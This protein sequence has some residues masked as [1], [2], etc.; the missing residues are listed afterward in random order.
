MS[1]RTDP[2]PAMRLR[3]RW[4]AVVIAGAASLPVGCARSKVAPPAFTIARTSPALGADADPVLLNDS[5]TVYFADTLS[6]LSVTADSVTV[7]DE[8]GR[9]VPGQLRSGANWV[10]FVPTPPLSPSLDDG[11]FRPA[12]HLRL[13][14]AGAPRPDAVC[15]ADGRRLHA[16][17]VYD[18][19]VAAADH[20]GAGLIAPLR[21]QPPELPFLLPPVDAPQVLPADAPVLRLH[22]T[23]PV[24]PTTLT[25]EAFDIRVLRNRETV[26]LRPRSVRATT[27]QFDEFPGSTVEVDLGAMPSLPSGRPAGPLVAGDWVSVDLVR[28]QGLTDYA[29]EAPLPTSQPQ[30]WNVVA[31]GNVALV[32]WP[33]SDGGIVGD[34]PLLPGFETV[35]G[36]VRPRVR[37]EA[38]DGSLGV[39]RPQRDTLLRPGQPFDRGD[40]QIVFSRGSEFPFLAI[41]IPAGV[42]VTVDG[43]QGPVQLLACGAIQIRGT[44]AVGDAAVPLRVRRYGTVA[45]R[46][47]LAT[48]PTSLVAAGDVIVRGRI[49][50]S[51]RQVA[52]ATALLIASAG[53]LHL[54]GELPYNTIL[55]VETSLLPRGEPAFLGT[56]GQVVVVA[57]M[58]TYGLAPGAAF[59]LRG[60]TPWRQLPADREGGRVLLFDASPQLHI[61]WQ[62]APADPVR[63]GEPDLQIGRV[64]RVAPAHDQEHIQVG[65]GGFVRF[66]LSAAVAAGQPLPT[67]RELRLVD[68]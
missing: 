49:E 18:I 53:R 40:G 42:T 15:S 39:F 62:A 48:S 47:L 26:R 24:L 57:A 46:D 4:F 41:D 23:L 33:S 34:D 29:G 11:S 43:S 2:I 1:S 61:G 56:L 3:G 17:A 31:G 12:S 16:T 44:L 52:D 65:F 20:R 64:G 35:S 30:I 22:F 54:H 60:A 19:H 55:A 59:E 66:E 36:T 13:M 14:V 58:F 63:K 28:D 5:I 67:L 25:P 45:V 8:D 32:E 37:C 38:G 68:R 21:P 9:Q 27:S 10:T 6:G 7:L 50:A 51:A